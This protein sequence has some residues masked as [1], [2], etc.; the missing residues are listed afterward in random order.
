MAHFAPAYAE[1][2]EAK[3]DRAVFIHRFIFRIALAAANVFAWIVVFRI[4]AL[5]TDTTSALALTA[6]LYALSNGITFILTP[7]T[8][9]ALRHGVRRA[10]V[11]GA[12]AAAASMVAIAALFLAPSIPRSEVFSLIALFTVVHGMYR[13]MY[14]IPYKVTEAAGIARSPAVLA[15]ESVIALMPALAG[16]VMTTVEHG[17]LLVFAL[18]AI[19]ILISAVLLTDI[20]DVPER[21]EWSY[22]E[23]LQQLMSSTH[24]RAVGLFI[25]DGIQGAVILLLWPLAAFLILG[26]S[27]QSLGAIVTATLC[28]TFLGRYLMRRF[29][30]HSTILRSPTVVASMVF[31]SWLLRL[32]ASSPVHILAIDAYYASG[33]QPRRFNIDSYTSE[34]TADGGH[35]VDEYTAL[36]E[37][38]LCVGRI[39]VSILFVVLV[40]TTAASVAFAGV[41]ITAAIAGAWSVSIAHRLEKQLY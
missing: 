3:R 9:M 19:G 38:G 15:R 33:T 41:L 20:P 39:A 6:S 36:K 30:K 34:Q 13:A 23:T 25:L 37:L 22:R 8:G 4:C 24:S 11:Y 17:S 40:L 31:S 7:L 10:L 21:F 1:V 32:T 28:I 14:W 35:F 16:Y 27:F 26:N 29:S 2:L 18:S 12:L 5:A